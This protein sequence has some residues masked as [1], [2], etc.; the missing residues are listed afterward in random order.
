MAGRLDVRDETRRARCHLRRPGTGAVPTGRL[1]AAHHPVSGRARRRAASTAACH[2][3]C[4]RC[5]HELPTTEPDG[6]PVHPRPRS[7]RRRLELPDVRHP[8]A[9]CSPSGSA[10]RLLHELLPSARLPTSPPARDPEV[11]RRPP[12]LTA[13][14]RCSGLPP[15]ARTRRSDRRSPNVQ[16]HDGVAVRRLRPPGTRP[17]RPRHRVPVR[18]RVRVLLLPRTDRKRTSVTADDLPVADEQEELHRPTAPE[19]PS[20]SRCPS[21]SPRTPSTAPAETVIG[22]RCRG[23]RYP[24][25]APVRSWRSAKRRTRPGKSPSS[26]VPSEQMP[27]AAQIGCGTSIGVVSPSGTGFIQISRSTFM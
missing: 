2:T 18:R 6:A 15:L 10:T 9:A 20:R 26:S 25:K 8:H 5:R 11:L 12:A 24:P 3:P 13:V 17:S 23:G 14:G 21:S 19:D 16:G 7:D 4:A 1:A 22:R 27:R